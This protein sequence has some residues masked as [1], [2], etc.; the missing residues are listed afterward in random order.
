MP[1]SVPSVDDIRNSFPHPTITAITGEPQYDEI[2]R[3]HKLLSSNAASVPSQLGGGNHGLLGHTI[4]PATYMNITGAAFL[5]PANPGAAPVIAANATAAQIGVATR[6][7]ERLYYEYHHT[8]RCDQ[9][10]KQQLLSCIE[11][12]YLDSICNPH[13]GF[14][15]VSTFQ[16]LEHLYLTYGRI[17]GMDL[18][19]NEKRMKT[20]YDP[21]QPID[22]LFR[23]IESGVEFADAGGA[24][25]S[26][27]QIV[28]IAYL[29]IFATGAYADECKLWNRRAPVAQTW[30]E[31]K[32]VFTTAYR[33]RRDLQ[34]LQRQATAGQHFGANH[35]RS[36]NQNNTTPP[37]P[38][39]THDYHADTRDALTAIANATLENGTHVA[40]LASDN[41]SLRAQ[42]ME[43]QTLMRSMQ[44]TL[45]G[46]NN[47]R[48][49][50]TPTPSPTPAT[51]TS[52]N[53]RDRSAS[54]P[55]N[56]RRRRDRG[57]DANS[58]HYCWSHGL[59]RSSNHTS[60]NC[61]TPEEGHERTATFT[62]RM[63]GSNFKC[64]G[65]V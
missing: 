37:T 10:L 53:P 27:R 57:Y 24:P 1:V 48:R 47:Q 22:T 60:A 39:D 54:P 40:N 13:T 2:R 32:Q 25:F 19:D 44:A 46:A 18:D 38:D 41:A 4:G 49:A 28:N 33:E 15:T 23:Q 11:P 26:P 21:N 55:P 42:L 36:N 34:H 52:N 50:P 17:T 29:L 43:M 58:R 45:L 7:F 6:E 63:G 16:I 12:M 9:A 30:I 31:F 61:R 51:N 14:T 62:N 59:T 3:V 35:M 56:R 65:V 8:T 64:N 5:L 20:K